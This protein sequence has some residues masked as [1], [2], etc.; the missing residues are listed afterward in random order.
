MGAISGFMETTS[1]LKCGG[2]NALVF[3]AAF[4]FADSKNNIE[5]IDNQMS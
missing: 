4:P 5:H 1:V 2:R 3:S